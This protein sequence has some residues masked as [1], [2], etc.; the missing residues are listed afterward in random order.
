MTTSESEELLNLTQRL[1][2]AIASRDWETYVE[3]CDESLT[4]FEPEAR[5][6]LVE[7]LDFHRFYLAPDS[8]RNE[9]SE[10]DPAT[11]PVENASSMQT[12]IASPHVRIMGD[13]AVVCYKRLIQ[14]E[15]ASQPWETHV[16]EETRI[17]QKQAGKWQHVHFHRS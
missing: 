15:N 16:W 12:T 10:Q 3:L 5:G 9:I 7:G 2:D 1:L 17:W 8:Y 14:V 11:G 6:S 13:S 4:C